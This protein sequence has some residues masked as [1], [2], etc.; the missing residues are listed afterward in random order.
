MDGDFIPCL[1]KKGKGLLNQRIGRLVSNKVHLT[2]FYYYLMKPL[3]DIEDITSS[4]TVKHLSHSD[5]EEL[6][7]PVPSYNE[8]KAIAQILGDM[9]EEI[10]ALETQSQKIQQLKQGMMQEL[11]TGKIRLVRPANQ[12]KEKSLAMAAEPES[13]FKNKSL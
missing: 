3:K 6:I 4:T 10:E 12:E 1:W 9:D 5:I 11:L 8:Q 13:T 7:L 2:F